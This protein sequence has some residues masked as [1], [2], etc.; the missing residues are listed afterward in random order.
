[1]QAPT[2]DELNPEISTLF[3]FKEI[4]FSVPS[5]Y[6]TETESPEQSNLSPISYS[7]F[8]EVPINL[9]EEISI[10]F[11]VLGSTTLSSAT[12]FPPSALP[13][14]ESP[15]TL[16]TEFSP[17]FTFSIFPSATSTVPTFSSTVTVL[18]EESSPPL[19]AAPSAFT[20][21]ESTFVFSTE[22][23]ASAPSTET[24]V[25][26]EFFITIEEPPST[27]TETS[28]LPF[29]IVKNELFTFSETT[30][31]TFFTFSSTTLAAFT[32]N[33][34]PPKS[35]F[36]IV[37]VELTE[38]SSLISF[39]VKSTVEPL[40]L[41]NEEIELSSSEPPSEAQETAANANAAAKNK[42]TNFF[43]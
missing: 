43:I 3:A 33:V 32:V 15:L 14:C 4:D 42:H 21:T 18:M 13:I 2:E 27:T 1:M 9:T 11:A 16:I 23:E 38:T 24:L 20:S 36:L 12:N 31:F 34:F 28:P 30:I 6:F 26:E 17:A 19:I 29:L 5:L 41:I 37:T 22:T 40:L 7:V 8:E 35:A 10:F 39:P 25:T